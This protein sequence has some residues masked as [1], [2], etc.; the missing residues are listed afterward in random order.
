MQNFIKS[1]SSG[2]INMA[3]VEAVWD[4]IEKYKGRHSNTLT[5]KIE[6]NG[7]GQQIQGKLEDTKSVSAKKQKKRKKET[8]N[9]KDLSENGIAQEEP[10]PKKT[11]KRKSG[12][13]SENIASDQSIKEIN[14]PTQNGEKLE[15]KKKK[16]KKSSNQPE[17]ENVNGEPSPDKKKSNSVDEN[18]EAQ[19]S[20]VVT[21]IETEKED[22][23][24]IPIIQEKENS[25]KKPKRNAKSIEPL[26]QEKHVTENNLLPESIDENGIAV[27]GKSKNKAKRKS[28]LEIENSSSEPAEKRAKQEATEQSLNEST[29]N[30]KFDFKMKIMEILQTVDSINPKKLQKRIKK[31]YLKETGAAEFSE[32]I[33]KKYNKKLKQIDNIE[34][35]ENNVQLIKIAT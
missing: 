4:I 35:T 32:K 19:Q 22:P 9:E 16:K 6:E 29:G 30:V 12:D 31:M 10:K 15:K 20:D 34:L 25:K 26:E 28:S 1:S 2:R 7:N 3:D 5:S 21:S 27:N 11:S 18:E 23:Q 24:P 33:L 8:V 14:V 17:A 13:V